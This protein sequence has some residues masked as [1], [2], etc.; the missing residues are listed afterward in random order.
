MIKLFLDDYRNPKDCVTYMHSRIG[1]DN[2]IYLEDWEIVHNYDEFVKFVKEN[3][4]IISHVSFDHDLADEHYTPEEY[5]E[6]I[7]ASAKWQSEQRYKEKTGYD[8]AK[9][10]KQ[11]YEENMLPL[12]IIYIHSMNPV[13]CQNIKNIFK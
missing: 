9:W 1:V 11:Y 5:W 13:G 4:G 12:P 7:E 2:P 10:L 6:P 3:A 8:A